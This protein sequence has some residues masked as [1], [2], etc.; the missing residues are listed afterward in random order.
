[1]KD[2]IQ[3]R[4]LFGA[5]HTIPTVKKKADWAMK[6]INRRVRRTFISFACVE[7]FFSAAVS[8]PSLVK[9]ERVDERLDISNE[10][11]SATKVYGRFRV[12][13]VFGIET[14]AQ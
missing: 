5:I 3:K 12:R 13:V 8:A 11:I 14:Q 10:L 6:W 2:P 9:E 1:M 4:N 7:G